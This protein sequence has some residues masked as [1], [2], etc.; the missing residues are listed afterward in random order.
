MPHRD[1]ET[2]Q[3]LAH[4]D[5]DEPVELVYADHEFVNFRLLATD[6]NGDST[7]NQVEYKIEDDV[8][9]LEND[10]LGMLG[11]MTAAA[12]L[13][14]SE[15]EPS[16][17]SLGG[18]RSIVEIGSNLAGDEFLGEANVDRGVEVIDDAGG[19][20]HSTRANDE[21]G[22]WAVLNPTITTQ[23]ADDA[24]GTGSGASI[25]HDRLTRYY[26]EETGGGPYID[27]TDDI[28]VGIRLSRGRT[29]TA[30]DTRVVGQMAF[31]VFE[32]ENRRQEFAPFD[33]GASMG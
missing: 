10:E 1:P 26:Y 33:P 4:G 32:Y 3:F 31:V 18:A 15:V 11:W 7:F 21:P 29:E 12:T 28:N 19:V 2:G 27:S 22:L 8:L 25:G 14:A 6:T 24:S 23:S 13:S 5:D 16:E 17:L 30:I 20:F 9:D